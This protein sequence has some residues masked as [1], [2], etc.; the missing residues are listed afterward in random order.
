MADFPPQ[1]IENIGGACI[2]TNGTPFMTAMQADLAAANFAG[3]IWPANNQAIYVPFVLDQPKT[4]KQMFWH[5]TAASGTMDVGIYDANANRLVS[6]GATTNAI[7]LQVGN[8]T[9]TLLVPGLYY[10]GILCSTIVTQNTWSSVVP[11]SCLRACGCQQQA[12]GAATLPNPAT[13]AVI[14]AAYLP[15]VGISFQATM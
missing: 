2:Q 12:V 6:L 7:T 10:A 13:F 5:N 15:M 4:A 14:T 11:I 9:D 1:Q 8:I 3:A